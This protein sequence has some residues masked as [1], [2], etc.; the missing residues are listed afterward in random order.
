[1]IYCECCEKEIVNEAYIDSNIDEVGLC[2]DCYEQNLGIV[3]ER[4]PGASQK[5]QEMVEREFAARKLRATG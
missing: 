5:R 1:M 3:I 4:E 2:L